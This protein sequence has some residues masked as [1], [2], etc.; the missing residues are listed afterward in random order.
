MQCEWPLT[1]TETERLLS[2]PTVAQHIDIYRVIHN[3]VRHFKFRNKYTQR[4]M[5]V[6]KPIERE[7]LQVFIYTYMYIY[8]YT[9]FMRSSMCSPLVKRHTSMR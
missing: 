5:V 3:S 6:L 8:I 1:E 2:R 4:M 9:Y 7:T